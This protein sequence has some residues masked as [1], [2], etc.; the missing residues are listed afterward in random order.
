MSGRHTGLFA[1]P[2]I[3]RED[4]GLMMAGAV[5]PADAAQEGTHA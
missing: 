4:I 3:A 2:D 1:A 5:G